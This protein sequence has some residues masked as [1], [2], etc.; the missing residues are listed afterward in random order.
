M[1]NWQYAVVGAGA[2]LLVGLIARSVIMAQYSFAGRYFA[3]AVWV[4]AAGAV[5]AGVVAFAA[6]RRPYALGL[7][8][9]LAGVIAT[10][11]ILFWRDST[12]LWVL[13]A[14]VVAV[15]AGAIGAFL[16]ITLR[17]LVGGDRLPT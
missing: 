16:G 4:A 15:F 17:W 5:A 8:T 6:P 7:V 3:V 14:V 9:G 10:G 2:T 1:R 13:V 12:L 11:L